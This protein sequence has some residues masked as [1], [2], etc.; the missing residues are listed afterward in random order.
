MAVPP[1]SSMRA[2]A[3]HH[4]HPV[5]GG[6]VSVSGKCAGTTVRIRPVRSAAT[7]HW[8]VQRRIVHSSGREIVPG[9]TVVPNGGVVR[10]DVEGVG[11][12]RG[13]IGN[14]TVLPS[15]GII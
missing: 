14:A 13:R 15:G 2:G 1:A 9:D 3:E 8:G 5:V 10:G 6:V 12:D 4:V 7:V 11:R